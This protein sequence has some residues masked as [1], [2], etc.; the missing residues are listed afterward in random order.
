MKN[1]GAMSVREFCGRYQIGRTTAYFE[2]NA[3]RLRAVKA[4]RRT[5]I[6]LEAAREWFDSL[7][8]IKPQR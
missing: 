3:G 8:Q 7:P 1:D 5:L 2:I 4:K 6:S